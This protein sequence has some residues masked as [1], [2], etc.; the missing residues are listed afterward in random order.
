MKPKKTSI[1]KKVLASDSPARQRREKPAKAPVKKDASAV[2]PPTPEIKT[3]KKPALPAK[4]GPQRKRAVRKLS[5]KTNSPASKKSKAPAITAAV[6]VAASGDTEAPPE[7]LPQQAL[8]RKRPDSSVRKIPSTIPP[9]L[10]EGDKPAGKSPTGPGKRYT[11]GVVPTREEGGAEG[12]LPESYG[13][14]QLLLVARDPHWL[15]AHWD[16]TREQQREY[17]SLSRDRHMVLRVYLAAPHGH[18]ATEVHVH[19]ESRHWFVHVTGAGKKYVAELGY[20]EMDGEWNAVAVSGATLTPP[21]SVS[22]TTFAEFATIPFEIP[23]AKLLSLVK[24]AVQEHKPLAQA[25]EEMRSEGHGELPR[26]GGNT[27][28][29]AAEW[30]PAQEQALA[31]VISMDDVQRVWMGSLEITELIRRQAVQEK[32]SAE[33]QAR[34]I[35]AA[36]TSP[37]AA[38]GAISSPVKP[39]AKSAKGFWFSVNAELVIYGATEADARVTI[40]GRPIRLRPDGTFSYRFALPDGQYSLPIVA[41]SSDQTDGRAAELEFTRATEYRGDVEQHPQSR[42]L[43]PPDPATL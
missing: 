19:P 43:N 22:P 40:G 39:G 37:A 13:T 4:T 25:I 7:K 35:S 28:G 1:K 21:D 26:M 16:F 17:N 31:K 2:K 11:L 24:D 14:R 30:T 8:T 9:I 10:F 6:P 5:L 38:P 20:Y 23:M 41:V 42:D 12:E 29:A 18:P 34:G 27:S 32:I 33:M 36:P 3:K 15:Y